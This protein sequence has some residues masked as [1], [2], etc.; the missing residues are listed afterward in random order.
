MAITLLLV[1]FDWLGLCDSGLSASVAVPS[2]LGV[3]PANEEDLGTRYLWK[4]SKASSRGMNCGLSG[5]EAAAE[6]DLLRGID[7][8]PVLAVPSPRVEAGGAVTV[9]LAL[10]V[11]R[12][13]PSTTPNMTWERTVRINSGLRKSSGLVAV[14][15]LRAPL[16]SL[17]VGER[18]VR[19]LVRRRGEDCGAEGAVCVAKGSFTQNQYCEH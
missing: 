2:L 11:R 4:M 18:E 12:W 7:R 1:R 10:D 14:T 17:V 5:L 15:N 9:F 3:L 8:G 19:L 6:S 13:R 16:S